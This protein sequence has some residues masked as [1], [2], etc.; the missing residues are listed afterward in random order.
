[1][2]N[3][4]KAIALPIANESL[5][6]IARTAY[7]QGIIVYLYGQLTIRDYKEFLSIENF[8]LTTNL[9]DSNE[10]ICDRV[11]QGFDTFFENT[12]IYNVICYSNNTLLHIGVRTISLLH[13]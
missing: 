1:M 8:A 13:I 10:I 2:L 4:Y 3:G 6:G 12:E 9:Y 7:R 5:M 11:A